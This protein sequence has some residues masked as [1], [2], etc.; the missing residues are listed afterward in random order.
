MALQFLL[1]VYHFLLFLTL[2]ASLTT[3]VSPSSTLAPR[4]P[5]SQVM[6]ENGTGC[7]CPPGLVKGGDNCTCPVG[8]TLEAAAQCKGRMVQNQQQNRGFSE[9]TFS[10]IWDISL[11]SLHVR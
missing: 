4:C 10:N 6:L 8:F 1:K 2:A 9:D 5:E 11:I 7:G 3:T